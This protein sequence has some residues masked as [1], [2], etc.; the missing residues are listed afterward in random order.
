VVKVTAIERFAEENRIDPRLLKAV[1]AV[2]A[3]GNGF[4]SDKSLKIRLE[5]HLVLGDYPGLSRWFSLGEVK[6]LDHFYKFPSFSTVWK[7]LHTGNQWDEYTGLLTA[8][9][10]INEKAFNYISMG[11]FQIMGFHWQRLG[12]TS[13]LQMFSFMSQSDDNDT[14]VGLRFIASDSNLLSA[15][16]RK[17]LH[18]FAKLYNGPA[19]VEYYVKRF[20]EELNQTRGLPDSQRGY[21]FDTNDVNTTESTVCQT[22]VQPMKINDI[23]KFTHEGQMIEGFIL[24]MSCD[25]VSFYTSDD[26]IFS[27][28]T[29]F[30]ITYLDTNSQNVRTV[31][32]SRVQMVDL[33]QTKSTT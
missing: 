32:F 28:S 23:I 22:G 26:N 33:L 30:F 18:T 16:Q 3:G 1:V 11:K 9:F 8:S 27:E 24:A 14:L 21:S 12:F 7:K 4:N 17:D 29:S 2:E 6:F 5:A 10:Q 20:T 13:S 25:A 15:L 19:N 31:K